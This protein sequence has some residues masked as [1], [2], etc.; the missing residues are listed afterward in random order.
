MAKAPT[1]AKRF[2]D[3]MIEVREKRAE[4]EETGSKR[5]AVEMLRAERKDTTENMVRAMEE[6]LGRCEDRDR[7]DR[8]LLRK[9]TTFTRFEREEK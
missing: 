4:Y 8:D 5:A 7:D 2:H 6:R 1:R 3:A 9:H